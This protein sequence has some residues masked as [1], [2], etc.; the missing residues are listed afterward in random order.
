VRYVRRAVEPGGEAVRALGQLIAVP[1]REGVLPRRKRAGRLPGRPHS[2]RDNDEVG[3]EKDE[4]DE[5]AR[6]ESSSYVTQ[7]SQSPGTS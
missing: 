2:G 1:L 6:E 7:I 5:V 4:E 3:D